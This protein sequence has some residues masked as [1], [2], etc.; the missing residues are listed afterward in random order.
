MQP[1][2]ESAVERLMLLL[3]QVAMVVIM[4]LTTLEIILRSFFDFSLE[5]TGE[6]SGYLLVAV[7][8]F[9]ASASQATDSFHHVELVQARLSPR[10]RLV[11][12]LVFN[13]A[14]LAASLLLLWFL[15]R[16]E[17]LSYSRGELSNSTLAL[18]MWIPRLVMPIGMAALC[19]ALA[20]TIFATFKAL[21]ARSIAENTQE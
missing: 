9:G 7:F 21:G 8:F 20:R 11:S 15:A 13:I 1:T 18:P 16:F 5:V 19:I 14:S 12:R 6:I 3:S 10:G 17:W 2:G 4:V